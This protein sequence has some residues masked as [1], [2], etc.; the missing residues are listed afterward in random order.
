ML[1]VVPFY[2]GDD[3]DLVEP[4]SA[5]LRRLFRRDVRILPPWFDPEEAFDGSRAQ[6]HST[7]ILAMLLDGPGERFERVLAVTGVDLFI[8][9][10][11]YVFGEAQLSGKAAVASV[12]R[13]RPEAYGLAP[14]RVLLLGRLVKEA[15][16]ELGHTHGLLHCTDAGCVMRSSTYVEEI[17]LKGPEFCE[18]CSAVL[19]GDEP[20]R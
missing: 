2:L 12:Q 18:A 1:A 14:D 6:Y 3:A 9:I 7:R 8:P 16:H 17:D 19:P 20:G 5:E 11:T 13:L 15:V 10:L 4:L